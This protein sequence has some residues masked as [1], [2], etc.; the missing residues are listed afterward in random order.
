VSVTV[1]SSAMVMLTGCVVSTGGRGRGFTRSRAVALVALP[2]LLD[3]T[4]RTW[5]LSSP[6]A[7]TK[8]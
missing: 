5:A 4:T 7:V 8:A 2:A 3:T 6:S 1:F